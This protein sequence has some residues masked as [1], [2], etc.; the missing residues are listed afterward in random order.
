MAVSKEEK[1]TVQGKKLGKGFKIGNH[2]KHLCFAR[3]QAS[4]KFWGRLRKKKGNEQLCIDN[5]VQ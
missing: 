4:V 2:C 3:K 5:D 1:K